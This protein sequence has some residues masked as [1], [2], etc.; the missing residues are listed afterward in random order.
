MAN[1][2]NANWPTRWPMMLP[3]PTAI[4]RSRGMVPNRQS[5][6]WP[7]SQ[8][9]P[10]YLE[11]GSPS[12]Q[13]YSYL[14]NN[15][16][17]ASAQPVYLSNNV[18]ALTHGGHWRSGV[19]PGGDIARLPLG[20]LMLTNPRF[21]PRRVKSRVKARNRLM[22]RALA[23]EAAGRRSR[24]HQRLV[25]NERARRLAA[26]ANQQRKANWGWRKTALS[27]E[28]SSSA[29]QPTLV[30]RMGARATGM[31]IPTGVPHLGAEP[32]PEPIATA[33]LTNLYGGLALS[34][35]GAGDCACGDSMVDK[36]RDWWDS[37]DQTMK[38]VYG[39]AAAFA[40]YHFFL[41]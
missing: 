4:P 3:L 17:L 7:Q 21:K 41:R 34:N 5:V 2:M 24:I 37:Q 36:A 14:K 11:P 13:P 26:A 9:A 35:T 28:A 10:L 22:Q 1:P 20:G 38:L 25:M 16:S 29:P 6:D 33:G 39:G 18:S 31:Q 23:V 27:V 30:H 32:P 15:V 19:G 12:F 40:A 8:F